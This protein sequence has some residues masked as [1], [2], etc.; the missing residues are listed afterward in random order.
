MDVITRIAHRLQQVDGVV[1]VA[2]GG[3]RARGT[4]RPDSDVDLG[5]YYREPL[6]TAALRRLATELSGPAVEVTEPGG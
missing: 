1:A 6:H 4:H 3:S 2:L 5:L